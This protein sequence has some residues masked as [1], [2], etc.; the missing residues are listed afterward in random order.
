MK[1][2]ICLL[3]ENLTRGQALIDKRMDCHNCLKK[4][5]C[6]NQEVEQ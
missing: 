5:E 4:I 6:K 1:T 2:L 3:N